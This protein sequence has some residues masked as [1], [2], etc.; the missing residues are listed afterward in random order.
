MT[1]RRIP[2]SLRYYKGNKDEQL[3][4]Q[5]LQ[6]YVPFRS[7]EE[8]LGS[9]PIEDVP[10]RY[11]HLQDHIEEVKKQ[12]MPFMEDVKEARRLAEE[13]D[14]AQ[15][16]E[17]IAAEMDPTL[18]QEDKE[19]EGQGMIE[20]PELGH[21]N[22][23]Q[24]EIDGGEV[25]ARKSAAI[26]GRIE[27]PDDTELKEKTRKLDENQRKVVDTVIKYCRGVVKA[28]VPG[29]YHPK[30]RH[31]MI[32]GAAGTGKSTVIKLCAQWA[33]KILL[34][35]GSDPDKPFVLKTAFMGTAA[36]NIEG[37]TLTSTFAMKF[38]NE[39]HGLGDKKRDEKRRDLKD[40]KI[41][42]IDE[43][44]MVKPDMLYQLDLIL[45]E[46]TQ[47][48]NEAYGGV[49]VL[50]FGDMFQLKPVLGGHVFMKPKNPQFHVTHAVEPRWPLLEVLNL[51]ENHR[52]GADREFADCLNRVQE[53][54]QGKL[55]AEDRALLGTRVRPEG[56]ADL[57][58]ASINIVCTKKKCS[59][60]NTKYINALEGEAVI[61][62]AINYKST[63]KNY[64]PGN[65]QVDG[66]IGAT[67]FMNELT[68]KIGAKVVM[69]WNVNTV[70]SLT[71]GQTGIVM[72]IIKDRKDEVDYLVIKFNQ[73][74]AGKQ[75]RL[76]SKQLQEKYPGGTKVEK[77]NL[78]YTLSGRSGSGSTA[79]LVQFPDWPTPSQP[80]RRKDRPTSFQ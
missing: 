54:E 67:G 43:I 68:L 62:K 42:I 57:K 78:T 39:Y 52:Q 20:H 59:E 4:Y 49:M 64:K 25:P 23:D 2:A 31:M 29:N 72:A 56:H 27:V 46:I 37:Q 9:L 18:V 44:S 77:F 24:Y 21:L 63:Q 75:K 65:I 73:E 12:V 70:D 51:T 14:K 16:I 35:V 58:G 71:N 69:I 66:T 80:T 13:A 7:E 61:I 22:P 74:R 17:S 8:E 34:A 50:A 41:V 48:K 33:Q 40:L 60:M 38:G 26:Y 1:R 45:K 19:D 15:K 11:M 76:E 30:P 47:K 36:A 28:R 53:V 6:M 32:H 55:T 79:N 5:E 10:V 3:Y